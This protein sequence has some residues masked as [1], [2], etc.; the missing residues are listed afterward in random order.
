MKPFP[1]FDDPIILASSS[2]RRRYLLGLVGIKHRVVTPCLNEDDHA[3][4]DPTRHV[5]RLASL[6]ARS[7]LG[8]VRRGIVL[9]ADTVVVAD[10][11]ILGKPKNKADA[12]RML[13]RLAGRWHTVYTGIAVVDAASGLEAVGCERSSVRIRAMSG[14]EIDAYI[15]TGEPMDK[16]GSY[17]IQGYGAAIVEQV[18]GCYFNVVGLPLVRLLYLVRQ[19]KRALDDGPGREAG[20]AP[21]KRSGARGAARRRVRRSGRTV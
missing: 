11:E 18:K 20:R 14:S 6:K 4:E 16:A 21:G 15:A 10:G 12:R 8:Q 13:G 7:V 5:L 1:F 9:G 3:H 2:P 17:G 19:L